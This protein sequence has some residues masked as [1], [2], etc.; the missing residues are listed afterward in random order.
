MKTRAVLW[1]VWLVT[2]FLHPGFSEVVD[3]IV[4]EVNGKAITRIDLRILQAFALAGYEKGDQVVLPLE[5]IL[6]EAVSRKVVIDVVQ[7]N[8]SL[9]DAEV[10]GL[11]ER[12]KSQFDPSHWQRALADFG[13]EEEDLRPYAEEILLYDKIIGLRFRQ[14]V[15]VSLKEIE[16]YYNEVI[17]PSQQAQGNEPRPMVQL[18]DDIESVIKRNKTEKLVTSWITNLRQQA[19]IRVNRQCLE[20]RDSKRAS[21]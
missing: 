18:L 9:T 13:I 17:V 11:M 2:A 20:Q 21:P 3:C 12:I 4:A 7:Q 14:G 5:K 15:E 16:A 10:N 6:E 8:I 1:I 19:E